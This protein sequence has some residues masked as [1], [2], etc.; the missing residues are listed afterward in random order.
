MNYK[1]LDQWLKRNEVNCVSLID[2]HDEGSFNPY[3]CDC[4]D[5]LATNTYSV[6]GYS[7]KYKEVFELGDICGDCLNYFYN[8]VN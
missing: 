2:D 7:P 1:K 6:H 5:S 3:G 8:G 4:C